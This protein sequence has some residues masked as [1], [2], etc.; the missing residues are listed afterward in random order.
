[1]GKD[2]NKKTPQ[3]DP[4]Q[5]NPPSSF[6]GRSTKILGLAASI[7]SKELGSRISQGM[8]KDPNLKKLK[9]LNVQMEQARRIV[10]DLTQLRGAAMKVGQLLTL[11]AQD[12]LPKEVS[13]ILTSL[14][15][16]AIP[17]RKEAVWK[18]LREDLGSKLEEL[19][20]ISQE[21][22]AAASIGQV[23]EAKL[24]NQKLA[25]KIQYPEISK[26]I[27]SD[28]KFLKR[29]VLSMS[30]FYKRKVDMSQ[31]L[32]EVA[33][34]VSQ[35]VNYKK[36]ADFLKKYKAHFESHPIFV[37]PEV[38]DFYS[39]HRVLTMS[40][41]E[42]LSF[43]DWLKTNPSLK[44]RKQLGNRFI[45]LYLKEFLELGLVQTDPNYG[46]FKIDPL[47]NK[48]EPYRIILLD[49]GSTRH[50]PDSFRRVYCE[51][52]RRVTKGDYE[53][54]LQYSIEQ[55][56]I[57]SRESRS[58]FSVYDKM[59][60]YLSEPFS[61]ESFDFTNGEFMKEIRSLS[62]QFIQKLEYTP[63]PRKLIFLHRKLAGVFFICRK[64]GVA[65]DLRPHAVALLE[66]PAPNKSSRIHST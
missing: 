7:A 56:F 60:R 24:E 35:E 58:C 45:E 37:V 39:S 38:F 53:S 55:G 25:I 21:P 16:K 23:H 62:R 8:E 27:D 11:E 57:D 43:D 31:M 44:T 66:Y 52:F 13:D 61:K 41:E 12:F 40:F 3:S 33:E 47:S 51:L 22:I 29:S 64:L 20:E 42:G 48:T 63:P 9:Q 26:T 34:V 59:V 46:N 15:D 54:A 5:D 28:L 14:Y 6:F 36:E 19:D 18:T 17:A 32:D 65:L 50:F 49:F 2:K 1:M 30:Q 10:K 4:K